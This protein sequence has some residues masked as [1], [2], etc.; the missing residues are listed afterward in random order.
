MV[1]AKLRSPGQPLGGEG[2][3]RQHV[4]LVAGPGGGPSPGVV[5]TALGRPGSRHRARPS[6]GRSSLLSEAP[7]AILLE[8]P[9]RR[10]KVFQL[11]HIVPGAFHAS[12]GVNFRAR[13]RAHAPPRRGISFPCGVE[14]PGLPGDDVCGWGPCTQNRGALGPGRRLARGGAAAAVLHEE[15]MLGPGAAP[16]PAG[17]QGRRQAC[18]RP[19]RPVWARLQA[20]HTK[21]RPGPWGAPRFTI[22]EGQSW[23]KEE[24][25]LPNH[26]GFKKNHW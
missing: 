11:V 1:P 17:G 7:G 2:C 14:I 18:S 21:R 16:R 13:A 15:P 4:A 25:L 5:L 19:E 12:G 3:L 24:Q 10:K 9:R 26:L 6:L 20:P 8:G 22:G 23:R